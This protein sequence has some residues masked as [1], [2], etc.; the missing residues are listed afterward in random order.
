MTVCLSVCRCVWARVWLSCVESVW[1]LYQQRRKELGQD[2]SSSDTQSQLSLPYYS[3]QQATP[4]L[5]LRCVCMCMCFFGNITLL[6]GIK[7]R[8][9]SV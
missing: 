4:E 5:L 1:R 6:C 2:W 8:S 3:R 7:C 9:V